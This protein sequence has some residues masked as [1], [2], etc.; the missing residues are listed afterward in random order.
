MPCYIFLVELRGIEPL[1]ENLLIQL[2]PGAG[3]LFNL[4]SF[5][6]GVQALKE[7]NRFLHDRLN[8][9]PP[10]HVHHSNDA[11]SRFVVLPRG[12]GGPQ[13]AALPSK[14]PKGQR[15]GSQSNVI[16]VVY[17]LK[18]EQFKRLLGSTR[19]SYLKIPVETFTAPC[20]RRFIVCCP[21]FCVLSRGPRHAWRSSHACR[22][23]FCLGTAQAR[24]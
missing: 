21:S 22:T 24:P 1:S 17:F 19:L 14:P 16:V 15:L 9:K 18:F 10:M 7:S 5:N 20:A 13:T 23:S 11:Q 4:F 2:S 3:R 12:T 8:G 6:A